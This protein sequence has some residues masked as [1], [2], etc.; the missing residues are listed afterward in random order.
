MSQTT[1]VVDNFLD[2]SPPPLRTSCKIILL[3]ILLLLLIIRIPQLSLT[4]SPWR[5]PILLI[6]H[7]PQTLILIRHPL[8]T[9]KGWTNILRAVLTCITLVLTL[10]HQKPPTLATILMQCTLIEPLAQPRA[11]KTQYSFLSAT[12]VG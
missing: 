2:G 11:S 9:T 8:P 4:H 10:L 7:G 6:I 1:E 3:T 5:N 12:D